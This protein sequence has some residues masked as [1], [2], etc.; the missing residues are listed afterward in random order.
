MSECSL[1]L[2]FELLASKLRFLLIFLIS[3]I[4]VA[5]FTQVLFSRL[6]TKTCYFSELLVFLIHLITW[7]TGFKSSTYAIVLLLDYLAK[8]L[9]ILCKRKTR[10]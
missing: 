1:V 6:L 3:N 7:L 5:V 8:G 9:L 10:W 4:S 2:L